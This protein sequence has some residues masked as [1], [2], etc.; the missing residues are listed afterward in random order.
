[1]STACLLSG[2]KGR[3][4]GHQKEGRVEGRVTTLVGQTALLLVC[5]EN[6]EKQFKGTEA[7]VLFAPR[8]SFRQKQT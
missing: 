3:V 1:M 2:N 7:V 8:M 5:R 6:A 4:R